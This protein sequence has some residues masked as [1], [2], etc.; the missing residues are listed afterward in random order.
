[1]FSYCPETNEPLL[2][3]VVNSRGYP[4]VTSYVDPDHCDKNFKTDI[5]TL[6]KTVP[7]RL[8]GDEEAWEDLSVV[9]VRS[10]HGCNYRLTYMGGMKI[11]PHEKIF[12]V[13]GKEH[14]SLR[15][16]TNTASLI[17]AG[18]PSL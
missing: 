14:G 1:M 18:V 13:L 3:L 17:C 4:M 9:I 7:S 8:M 2:F 16:R 12:L 6:Q 11:Q 15:T 5:S 10:T